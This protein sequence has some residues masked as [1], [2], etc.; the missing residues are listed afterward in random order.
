LRLLKYIYSKKRKRAA[1]TVTDIVIEN[2][3]YEKR[4]RK[5]LKPES[6]EVNNDIIT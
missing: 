2:F 3:W 1:N 4:M 5:M 6:I